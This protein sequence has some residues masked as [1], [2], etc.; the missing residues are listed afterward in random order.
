MALLTKRHLRGIRNNNPGNIRRNAIQWKGMQAVQNDKAFVQFISP[1]YGFRAMVR[2]LRSYQGRGLN[3]VRE[4]IR[5]YAP[6][7]EN[8]TENY[9]N[10]V[11][12]RLSVKPNDQLEVE[13][14][15]SELIQAITVFEN[16]PLYADFYELA[17]IDR[18]IALA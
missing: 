2:I 8:K 9:I 13:S 4:I 14:R 5:T 1:E 17:A 15:M 3:S 6:A 18:G 16:G 12:G 7:T 10:F 11:A